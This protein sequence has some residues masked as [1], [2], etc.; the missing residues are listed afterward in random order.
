MCSLKLDAVQGEFRGLCDCARVI[1]IVSCTQKE[2]LNCRVQFSASTSC[3]WNK[4]SDMLLTSA[5][6]VVQSGQPAVHPPPGGPEC[7]HCVSVPPTHHMLHRDCC[8]P[9]WVEQDVYKYSMLGNSNE[10]GC[11]GIMN[12]LIGTFANNLSSRGGSTSDRYK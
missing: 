12:Q 4:L 9:P 8:V 10:R 1:G 7:P 3:R 6:Q 5:H 2:I 11:C